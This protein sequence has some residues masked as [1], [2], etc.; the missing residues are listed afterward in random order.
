MSNERIELPLETVTKWLKERFRNEGHPAAT[1][2]MGMNGI[3]YYPEDVAVELE[4]FAAA[5]TPPASSDAV[6]V[7]ALIGKL[8]QVLHT[9]CKDH[10]FQQYCTARKLIIAHTAARVE[11]AV[12][13]LRDAIGT[14]IAYLEDNCPE[15]AL[16]T[17]KVAR[18]DATPAQ[19]VG[20]VGAISKR[21]SDVEWQIKQ[22]EDNGGNVPDYLYEQLE[23]LESALAAATKEGR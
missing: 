13:P 1:P 19:N 11:E 7:D 6:E 3:A 17:L 4:A 14:A 18:G 16:L 23:E 5:M 2:F 9:P 10:L 12:R 15:S 8:D 20:E 22:I 21:K